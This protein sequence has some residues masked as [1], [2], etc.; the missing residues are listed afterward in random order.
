MKFL[1]ASNDNGGF[2]RIECIRGTDTSK[3]DGV[4]PKPIETFANDFSSSSHINKFTVFQEKYLVCARVDGTVS[5]YKY[6]R[7]DDTDA[8]MFPLLHSYTLPVESHDKPIALIKVEKFDSVIIAFESCKVFLLQ[9]SES[10]DLEPVL[11]TIPNPK[12]ISDFTDHPEHLGVFAYGGKE[13]DLKIIKFFDSKVTLKEFKKLYKTQKFQSQLLFL[14][15]NVKP[16]HLDLRVPISISKIKFVTKSVAKGFKVVVATGYGQLRIYDTTHGKRPLHDFKICDQ[17][18]VSLTLVDNEQ[19]VVVTSTS[20]LI[21]KYSLVEID[22]QAYKTNSATAGTVV[23]PVAKLLGKY[24]EGG[25]T[26]ATFGVDSSSDII[27]TGGLDRYLR[28][29]NTDS[30]AITAKV[31][32]GVE[33]SDVII[34]DHEDDIEDEL[35]SD[36]VAKQSKKRKRNEDKEESDDDEELWNQLEQSS[37]KASK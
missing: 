14:A 1:V 35:I 36:S 15:K 5:I 37:K 28:V 18:L 16:D 3:K 7:F 2:K 25:N 26:G 8:E 4:Q 11:L 6:V 31:Y 20:S 29:Y 13:N 33:I 22:N 30:R 9:L 17:S 27:A 10:F 19:A 23:K 32:V 24:S 12:P 21:A 34:V